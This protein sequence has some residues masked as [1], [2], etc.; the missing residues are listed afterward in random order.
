M[1]T[2]AIL[3]IIDVMASAGLR[4]TNKNHLDTF[5]KVMNDTLDADILIMGNSRGGCSYNPYYFDSILSQ[6]TWNISVSGQPFGVSYLRYSL[7]MHN[8]IPP[9]LIL[10]NI[11]YAEMGMYLNGYEREQYFPYIKDKRLYKTLKDNEFSWLDFHFPLYRYRGNYK[12]VGIGLS[13]FFGIYHIKSKQYKGYFNK[14]SSWDGAGLKKQIACGR[15]IICRMDD[16][17]YYLMNV[18]MET[19][20]D[21][22]TKVVMV[23]APVYHELKENLES[24]NDTLMKRYEELSCKFDVPIL[25]YTSLPMNYDTTCFNNANHVNT[26]G[27][28]MFSIRLAQDIDSLGILK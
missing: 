12:Y 7:Y 1:M 4:K 6:N 21:N 5:N 13:E 24:K 28:T 26:K 14:N 15:K 2:L 19:A 20:K 11:D 23:Y 8:N 10:L 3:T 22:G 17:A 27:A 25:D 9:K 16:E 18:F